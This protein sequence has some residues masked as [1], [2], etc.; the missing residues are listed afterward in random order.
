[1]AQKWFCLM[2]PTAIGKTD[3]ACELLHHFPCE[4][5][6][7]DSAMIYRDMNIGSAKP[8]AAILAQ[9]PHHL[10]DILSPEETYS[11]AQC[12]TDVRHCAEAIE[13]RGNIPL[14]V[15]GT[16]MYFRALQQGLSALPTADPTIRNA[17]MLEAEV[18]GWAYMHQQLT[19]VDPQTAQRIHTNDTQRILRAL[20]VFTL[21]QQPLS[22]WQETTQPPIQRQFINLI[23]LPEERSELHDRIALRF[24][25]MIANGFIDEVQHLRQKYH[26]S[27]A[28]PSMRCVG[29]RQV[30]AYLEEHTDLTILTEKGIAATRQLAKRQMTW[31]RHWPESHIFSVGKTLNLRE[32]IAFVQQITDN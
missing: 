17:L 13:A 32:M 12:C 30:W 16:M 29:Y 1:M 2:G 26:L 14:L 4:I 19:A 25:A 21:T 3:L 6:S 31:L 11:V 20:E 7:I 23:L 8:D 28:H 9:A 10:I 15:G 18:Q 27:A 22:L 5:I 24:K